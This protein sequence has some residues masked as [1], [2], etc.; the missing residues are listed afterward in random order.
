MVSAQHYETVKGCMKDNTGT[1]K[2][3]ML[4]ALV[5]A[6]YLASDDSFTGYAENRGASKR[7]CKQRRQTPTH[8]I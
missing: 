1:G 6:A 7:V 3:W 2:A 8:G 4:T 5:N